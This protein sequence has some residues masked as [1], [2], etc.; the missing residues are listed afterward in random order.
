[1]KYGFFELFVN[2]ILRF[3]FVIL[4][5]VFPSRDQAH[6][7]TFASCRWQRDALFPR[8]KLGP[9]CVHERSSCVAVSIAFIL[10]IC[11]IVRRRLLRIAAVRQW[12]RQ[13]QGLIYHNESGCEQLHNDVVPFL[14]VA[15][16]L[17][18]SAR[19]RA[20]C[21]VPNTSADNGQNANGFLMT[22]C[23]T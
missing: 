1:M 10:S 7:S 9:H 11:S 6:N 22:C 15:A 18:G 8:G 13:R 23:I 19:P 12:N 4:H 17:I 3:V 21:S 2:E 20:A 5:P 16:C 14:P